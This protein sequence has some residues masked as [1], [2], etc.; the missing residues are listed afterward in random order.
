M[1]LPASWVDSLFGRLGVRYGTA[2]LRQYE[3]FDL[4]IVKADW[5]EVLNGFDGESIAYGLR[6]LPADKPPTAMQFRDQCRR[7][8]RP[9]PPKAIAGPKPDPARV[10]ELV[11]RIEPKDVDPRE[12]ARRLQRREQQ[13]ERLTLA[14]REM[15]REA[16]KGAA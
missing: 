12:W 3:G 14:Q 9:E 11:S 7:A 5:A 4:A 6:Y 15:W 13:G 8:P 16:L 1:S 10:A 2:F